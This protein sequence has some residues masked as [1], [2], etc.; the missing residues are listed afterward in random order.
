M[1]IVDS[2]CYELKLAGFDQEEIDGLAE[3]LDIEDVYLSDIERVH[4]FRI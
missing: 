4:C 2:A 1:S 3:I